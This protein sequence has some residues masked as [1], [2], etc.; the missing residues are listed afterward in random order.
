MILSP[1]VDT[2]NANAVRIAKTHD[3]CF[4]GEIEFSFWLTKAKIIAITGTNGKT[5]T[6]HL[7]YEALR[8]K[9][10]RVFL[11]GNIG[12]PF[13]SFVLKTKK[14][15]LVVLE[16]S[17]FQLET[18]RSFKPYVSA[19]LNVAPDH[20]DRYA[21][22]KD[23]FD[24][25]MDIFKNQDKDDWAVVNARIDLRGNGHKLKAKIVRFSDEFPNENFSCVY[26]I[27][28][29]FGV[30]R[31]VAAGVFAG[32]KGLPHRMQFLRQIRRI[33]FIND[34]KATNPASVVWALGSLN[35]PVILIA[36]GKDKG[37][38]FS[39]IV[40]H[41]KGVKKVFLFGEAR[42]RI[43]NEI[44]SYVETLTLTSLKDCVSESFKQAEEGDVVL[45]SPMC[46][47]F[48]MFSDYVERGNKFI[49]IVESF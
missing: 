30:S 23:Y 7:T 11:G 47:S 15:D 16:I 14:D 41:L 38:D 43:Q 32:F 9:N 29:I 46:S 28:G 6:S 1:G 26:K 10:R 8:R 18:I 2:A 21:A 5:T 33:S 22:F 40:P 44:G 25:K 45:F 17:S 20:L 13:S 27:A 3:I 24:L 4:V 31:K 39:G 19:L 35:A 37:L 34:S 36:G 49:E 12:T 48:D 42:R